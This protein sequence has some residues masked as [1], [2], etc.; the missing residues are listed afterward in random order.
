MNEQLK[1]VGKQTN[2]IG[3][4][5][6]ENAKIGTDSNMVSF[7]PGVPAQPPHSQRGAGQ[8]GKINITNRYPEDYGTSV[9]YALFNQIRF[10]ELSIDCGGM[11]IN[12]THALLHGLDK[13]E[14][15]KRA[16]ELE[17]GKTSIHHRHSKVQ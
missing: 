8:R 1:S 6:R 7:L 4:D 12:H 14:E 9:T 17:K 10:T 11:T 5:L 13:L 15:K 3:F 2:L 16:D